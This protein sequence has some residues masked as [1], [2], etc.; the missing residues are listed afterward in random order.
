MPY[1]VVGIIGAAFHCLITHIDGISACFGD[2]GLVTG[3][4]LTVLMLRGLYDAYRTSLK[5]ILVILIV[6]G[7]KSESRSSCR[8]P[9]TVVVVF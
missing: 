4:A 1:G 3:K 8:L 5:G 2:S 6:T 7:M 9:R